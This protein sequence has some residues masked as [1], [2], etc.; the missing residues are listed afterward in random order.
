MGNVDELSRRRGGYGGISSGE[1]RLEESGV[2]IDG[3]T[4]SMFEKR[5][6]VLC[7]YIYC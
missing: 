4:F 7:M 3:F 1:V 6:R 5:H 2:E